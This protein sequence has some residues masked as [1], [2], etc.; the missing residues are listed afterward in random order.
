MFAKK[1][2]GADPLF[3]QL[4]D[5]F[6][7]D[8]GGSPVTPEEMGAGVPDLTSS[9]LCPATDR[10]T[11][12]SCAI[13]ALGSMIGTTMTHEIGH[14]LGLADPYGSDFHNP[15]DYPGRLMDSGGARDLPERVEIG[16]G[17]SVFCD[18]EYEYLRQILPSDTPAPNIER[19]MCF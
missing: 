8:R 18:S 19:P 6:R 9:D 15:G 4:F 1:L 5:P 16:A 2:D 13:W 14:S 17:P 10:P 12:I 11:Q 3:D 7:A